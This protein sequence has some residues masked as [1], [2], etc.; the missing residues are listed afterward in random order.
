MSLKTVSAPGTTM[1]TSAK[2][3]AATMSLDLTTSH[4]AST[5]RS[6]PSSTTASPVGLYSTTENLL[7]ATPSTFLPFTTE[8]DALTDTTPDIRSTTQEQVETLQTTSQSATF[9]FTTDNAEISASLGG[10]TYLTRLQFS[11]DEPSNGVTTVV[12]PLRT[13]QELATTVPVFR[14]TTRKHT[15]SLETT[16]QPSTTVANVV[17]TE[18]ATLLED[19]T[20]STIS[21]SAAFTTHRTTDASR[22]ATEPVISPTTASEAC[23]SQPCQNG[24]VCSDVFE[25]YEC[26]CPLGFVGA[27]C[28]LIDLCIPSPCYNGAKCSMNSHQNFTCTCARGYNGA[29]CADDIDECEEEGDCPDRSECVNSI[30]S[31]TC[32]CI[33]GFKGQECSERDFCADGPCLNN[34]TCVSVVEKFSCE[35]KGGYTGTRCET[36]IESPCQPSPCLNGGECMFGQGDGQ[37]QCLCGQQFLGENCEIDTDIFSCKMYVEG[38][39]VDTET[40]KTDTANLIKST[41]ADNAGSYSTVEVVLVSTADYES[42]ETGEPITL[43]TYLVLVNGTALTPAEVTDLME[44]TSDDVMDDIVSYKPFKGNVS[45]RS[46]MTWAQQYWYVILLST[47]GAATIVLLISCLLSRAYKAKKQKQKV[48]SVD[49]CDASKEVMSV[50]AEVYLASHLDAFSCE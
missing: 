12:H 3:P 17:G 30:G 28:E 34:A 11:T 47:T 24:G 8:I 27:D 4:E 38:A 6:S 10:H 26:S 31:Y 44:G 2:S 22:S 25:G 1:D 29:L 46:E 37:P 48:H 45:A 50:Q 18:S 43:V 7:E 13:E 19:Q 35:C 39:S 20:Q 15:T 33:Q 36:I 9:D 14:P 16:V 21:S 42:A 40:F 32:V 5:V 49:E 41:M 23:G